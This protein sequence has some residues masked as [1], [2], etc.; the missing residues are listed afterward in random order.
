MEL[1]AILRVL[2]R[3]RVAVGA[4][5]LLALVVGF[6]MASPTQ[7]SGVAWTTVA[8][9]TTPS[10]LVAPSPAGADTLSWRSSLVTH[11]MAGDEVRARVAREVGVPAA[12]LAILEPALH[13]PS[14][15][16]A[17]PRRATEAAARL[18][19]PYVVTLTATEETATISMVAMA[20]ER[21]AAKR[22]GDATVRALEAQ[23]SPAEGATIQPF[24]VVPAA[25]VAAREVVSKRGQLTGV[26]AAFAFVVAWCAAIAAVPDRRRRRAYLRRLGVARTPAG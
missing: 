3:R 1:V 17:L 5:A 20:P 13:V 18:R 23:G 25:P 9:D 8:L 7:R 12:S 26:G 4:G 19:E 11:V 22:L 21:D 14:V 16:A 6:G 10:Q 2:W 15:P 24:D